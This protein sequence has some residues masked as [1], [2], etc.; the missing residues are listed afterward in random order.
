MVTSRVHVPIPMDP[1]ERIRALRVVR[2]AYRRRKKP[3]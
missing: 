3:S 1:V 2:E